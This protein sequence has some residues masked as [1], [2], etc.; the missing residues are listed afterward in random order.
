MRPHPPG[1]EIIGEMEI[2]KLRDEYLRRIGEH[3][4]LQRFNNTLI[5]V[6]RAAFQTET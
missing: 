4:S 2:L 6:R 1:S 3:Y 5:T